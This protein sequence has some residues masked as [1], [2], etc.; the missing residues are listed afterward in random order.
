MKRQVD[1][2]K[3]IDLF[4]EIQETFPHLTMKLEQDHPHADLNMDIPGQ[5]GLK[6]KVNLNLQGDELHLSAGEMFWL[7]WFPCTD[8]QVVANYRE[9]V[10]GLL[11]GKCRILESYVGTH[12]CKAQLQMPDGSDW[13]VIG[14]SASG[15]WLLVPFFRSTQVLQ[16]R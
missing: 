5:D 8:D 14:N 16:N 12:G 9:A 15:F 2:Q 6:F 10:F 3:I 7:E 4:Q 1:R 13:K 11:S